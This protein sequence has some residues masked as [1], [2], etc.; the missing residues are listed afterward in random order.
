MR[1]AGMTTAS[2]TVIRRQRDPE[3]KR[4]VELAAAGKLAETIAALSEQLR[5]TQIAAPAD[6]YRAIAE[7]YLRSHQAG[8]TTLVVSPAIEE[9]AELNRVIRELLVARGLVARKSVE[10]MTLTNLDLPRAQRAHARHY[11]IGDVIRFRRGSTKLG[12]AAGGYATV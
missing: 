1:Q 11:E 6:R 2:L 4:A 7:D 5:I 12:I 8:Q 9:R 3:L 10:L